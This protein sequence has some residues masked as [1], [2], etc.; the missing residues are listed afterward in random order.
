MKVTIDPRHGHCDACG[1]C[2]QDDGAPG[3]RIRA[4]SNAQLRAVGW[5]VDDNRVGC[6]DHPVTS[7]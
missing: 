3:S 1:R 4:V 2:A 6:P 5:S 7:R